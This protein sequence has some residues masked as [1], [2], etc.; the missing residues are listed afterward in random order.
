MSCLSSF[1]LPNLC[2]QRLESTLVTRTFMA[3]PGTAGTA[4]TQTFAVPNG[5]CAFVVEMWGGGGSG[6]TATGGV[7]GQLAGGGGAGGYLRSTVRVEGC[8][9]FN[10]VVGAGGSAPSGASV[11]TDGGDTTFIG[12]GVNYIARGG[13]GGQLSSAS[14]LG[15]GGEGGMAQFIAGGNGFVSKGGTGN[16]GASFVNQPNGGGATSGG[17]GG[18]GALQAY[19][20]Y[21]ATNGYAEVGSLPGAGGG[22]G[23][24][25][26]TVGN[27]SKPGAA[28]ADGMVLIQYSETRAI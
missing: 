25:A 12:S 16:A 19:Q 17:A 22:G 21:A 8:Q 20:G 6:G 18:V 3:A 5:V 23:Y 11:G 27:V 7:V 26:E 1:A 28:G 2:A 15:L 13:Q 24:I 14:Q 10:I 4:G 9:V